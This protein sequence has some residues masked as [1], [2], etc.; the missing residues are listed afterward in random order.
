[1]VIGRAPS[2]IEHSVRTLIV[3]RVFAIAL[4]CQGLNDDD[5]ILTHPAFGWALR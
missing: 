5:P 1:L 2:V 3:Q 4:G